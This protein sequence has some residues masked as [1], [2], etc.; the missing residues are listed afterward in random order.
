MVHGEPT[1]PLSLLIV[2][3]G[4]GEDRHA[5]NCF[6]VFNLLTRGLLDDTPSTLGL[7]STYTPQVNFKVV[8]VESRSDVDRAVALDAVLCCE[9]RP[10]VASDKYKWVIRPHA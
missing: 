8:D 7:D 3:G 10:H 1:I 4:D 9:L 5:S 6:V 2:T